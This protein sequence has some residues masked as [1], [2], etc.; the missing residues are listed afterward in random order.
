[1]SDETLPPLVDLTLSV[2]TDNKDARVILRP[3]G[4]ELECR[5]KNGRIYFDV[6]RVDIHSVAEVIE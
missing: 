2:K 4:R 5:Y 1:M 3:E 6:D